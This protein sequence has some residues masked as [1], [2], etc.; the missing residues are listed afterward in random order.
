MND[1]IIQHVQ[2]CRACQYHQKDKPEEPILTHKIPER[3]WQ[4]VGADIY[5][6]ERINYLVIAD[7]YSGALHS[8]D[9]TQSSSTQTT[10]S[11]APTNDKDLPC[12]QSELPSSADQPVPSI[13]SPGAGNET[14]VTTRSGRAARKPERYGF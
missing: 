13:L 5:Q 4:I 8:Q 1:D 3:P 11:V 7:S 14:C 10:T 2:T 6:L 12:V 9:A